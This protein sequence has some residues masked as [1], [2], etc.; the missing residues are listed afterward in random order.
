MSQFLSKHWRILSSYENIDS[1]KT[2]FGKTLVIS[3]KIIDRRTTKS[4]SLEL[5]QDLDGCT[6]LSQEDHE[7]FTYALAAYRAAGVGG[8]QLRSF[9]DGFWH[10][11][12]SGRTFWAYGQ[13]EVEK[14]VGGITEFELY[15]AP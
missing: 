7:E 10:V 13:L 1:F 15:V 9:I 14:L 3:S 4:L 6:F 2:N 5:K 12:P 11:I 8:V